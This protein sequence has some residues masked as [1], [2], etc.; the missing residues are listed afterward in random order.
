MVAI[1]MIALAAAPAQAQIAN[2]TFSLGFPN[3]TDWNVASGTVATAFFNEAGMPTDPFFYLSIDSTGTGGATPHSNPGGFGTDASGTAL[4]TQSFTTGDA[5]NTLLTFDFVMVTA[6]TGEADFVEASISDGSS[7]YNIARIDTSMVSGGFSALMSPSVDLGAVFPGATE[8]TVFEIRLHVGDL[9][10]GSPSKGYFDNF[11]LTQGTPFPFN[12]VVFEDLGASHRIGMTSVDPFARCWHFLS[13]NVSGAVGGGSL[14]GLYPDPL[15]FEIAA[16]PVGT[17][18][19]HVFT[20]ANGSYQT[21]LPTAAVASG[22]TFDYLIVVFQGD[23]VTDVTP[24][25]RYVWP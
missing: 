7:T 10:G 2:P 24:P 5:Q 4:V 13:G 15:I 14:F 18:G 3:A 9:S 23:T 11:T 20:D 16:Y 1:T 8:N 25:K 12:D 6:N 19:L 17:P 21:F 22:T